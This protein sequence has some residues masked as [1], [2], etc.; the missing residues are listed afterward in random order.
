MANSQGI[1]FQFTRV[2]IVDDDNVMSWISSLHITSGDCATVP[3]VTASQPQLGRERFRIEPHI[4]IL[5]L[6][7]SLLHGRHP[8]FVTA[9]LSQNIGAKTPPLCHSVS[10]AFN[11]EQR[12][13]KMGWEKKFNSFIA[14]SEGAK[15]FL[16]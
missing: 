9:S 7:D 4:N 13:R 16:K 11:T 6:Q 15:W 8:A 1:H 5:E 10:L 14:G 2:K 3:G 12:P